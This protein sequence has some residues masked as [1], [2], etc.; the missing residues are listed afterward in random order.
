MQPLPP[1]FAFAILAMPLA[2]NASAWDVWTVCQTR[3][4]L[5]DELPEPA[6]AVRL[7]AAR[8][9]WES[10]QILVRSS[11][12]VRGVTI[13][14]GDLRGPDGYVLPGAAA[15][16]YRQHALYL[17]KATSRHPDFRPGWYP[18]A[19]IP[20]R[21]PTT[22]QP[23]ADARFVAV[24]FE[25]PAEQTHG[26]WVD[27]CVPEDAPAGEYRG[28]YRVRAADGRERTIPVK[29]TV[30]GFTLPRVAA[31]RTALGSPASKLRGYYAYLVRNGQRS[32]APD[33]QQVDRQCAEM[34][35]RHRINVAPPPVGD[36][37]I[38]RADGT[39]EVPSEMIV[40][41][42]RF[43]DTYH[44]NALQ[45]PHPKTAVRDPVAE[46][47]KLRRWLAAW[48]R[49]ADALD[50]PGVLFYIYLKD[51]PNDPAA[52]AEVRRWGEAIRAARSVVQV[53]VVEQTRPQQAAW[54][55]LYGAVDIWCP[56]FAAFLP[57]SAARRQAAGETIWAYTALCQG[58]PTPWWQIDRPLV[59]YRVPAWIAWRYRIRGLLYWGNMC[60]WEEVADPWTEPATFHTGGG[61]R[62]QV[63]NGEGTLVYPGREVGFDG[64]VPSM[65]LKA[66]RDAVEDY[67]YLYLLEKA[68]RA[69]EAERL[70]APLVPDWFSWQTSPEAYEQIRH[71]LAARLIA[72][73]TF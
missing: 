50:R 73:A 24:P 29:L 44:V 33:W 51:E 17:G 16:L 26:F 52:Y 42:R 1:L 21:H 49:A 30:W 58:T 68:G 40:A 4:V 69:E 61:F 45:L 62:R 12:P 28:E 70:V 38:A 5:R 60:Y 47:E 10:F 13:E 66:L 54:G 63:F 18:D 20:F 9:E 55:D 19:L 25:L 41:F 31:L 57:E 27:I 46:G 48:D 2:S 35:T 32:T 37:P 23:L 64:L 67:D 59:N 65:R 43:V 72:D 8:R 39:F 56:L 71:K 14:P 7:A 6:G 15:R 3:R 53:L 36:L 11:E 22:R 34:L